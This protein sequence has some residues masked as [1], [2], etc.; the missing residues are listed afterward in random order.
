MQTTNRRRPALVDG[1]KVLN[2]R[3][4]GVFLLLTAL[5]TAM[6]VLGRLASDTDRSGLDESLAAIASNMFP[7]VLAGAGRLA[8][9]ITLLLA[10]HYLR[11]RGLANRDR[12]SR[13][14]FPL[15]TL[16]G[17]ANAVSGGLA[18]VPARV[19]STIL[20]LDSSFGMPPGVRT[21]ADLHSLTGTVSFA[22]AGLGL[23]ALCGTLWR[24]G[25]VL[26]GLALLTAALGLGMQF[27]WVDA[28]TAPH[29]VSGAAYLI[30]LVTVGGILVSA[31]AVAIPDRNAAA[32]T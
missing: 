5:A 15:L 30:W 14:V 9:G 23:V 26:R 25:G 6:S 10:A 28:A 21:V 22:L 27:I 8:S 7:Y 18:I 19:A 16:S 1:R 29:R 11:G 3:M 12:V 31:P 4:A 17:I 20:P 24:A 2:A 32:P 13:F